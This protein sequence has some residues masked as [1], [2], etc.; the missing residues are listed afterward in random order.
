MLVGGL[1]K[2]SKRK[3]KGARHKT[4]AKGIEHGE[5]CRF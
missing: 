2:I 3:A 4:K 1:I 5:D